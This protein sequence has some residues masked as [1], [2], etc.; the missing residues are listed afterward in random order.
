MTN[1]YT[2]YFASSCVR[3]SC[4]FLLFWLDP[5]G[6]SSRDHHKVYILRGHREK[7]SYTSI[8][9]RRISLVVVPKI[10]FLYLIILFQ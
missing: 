6:S 5:Q 7:Y 10:A 4:L 3:D 9:R 2:K 1:I 8:V